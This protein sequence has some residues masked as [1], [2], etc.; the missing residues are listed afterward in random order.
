MNS[1]C[2]T[3]NFSCK[4]H[5]VPLTGKKWSWS[6]SRAEIEKVDAAIEHNSSISGT[7]YVFHP[8]DSM[9]AWSDAETCSNQWIYDISTRVDYPLQVEFFSLQTQLKKGQTTRTN[10]SNFVDGRM[11][12]RFGF[13][14]FWWNGNC[15]FKHVRNA[16]R[17]LRNVED[18]INIKSATA[19]WW[20]QTILLSLFS[21]FFSC[22]RW[23]SKLI[24][25]SLRF[26]QFDETTSASLFFVQQCGFNDDVA[27]RE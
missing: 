25:H 23:N 24:L 19:T 27:G 10:C 8:H 4:C 15:F 20:C 17:N 6:V 2:D 26:M 12:K 11:E 1:G 5:R 7:A 22:V 3:E 16:H 13:T 21:P 9:C 14:G 18:K